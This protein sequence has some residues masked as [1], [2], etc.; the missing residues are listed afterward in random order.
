MQFNIYKALWTTATKMSL[1][2]NGNVNFSRD[3]ERQKKEEKK[4]HQIEYFTKSVICL[5]TW[6]WLFIFVNMQF[7]YCDTSDLLWKYTTRWISF[8]VSHTIDHPVPWHLLFSWFISSL[9]PYHFPALMINNKKY[10]YKHAGILNV[11]RKRGE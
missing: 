4:M 9:Q 7:S 11:K 10:I 6:L 5:W 1:T 2:L 8:A 3:C